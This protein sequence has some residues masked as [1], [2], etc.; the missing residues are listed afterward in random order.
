M[1]L[2]HEFLQAN[3]DGSAHMEVPLLEP[4]CCENMWG[5]IGCAIFVPVRS[6]LIVSRGSARYGIALCLWGAAR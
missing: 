6:R 2:V 5:R 4:E 1:L 3:P